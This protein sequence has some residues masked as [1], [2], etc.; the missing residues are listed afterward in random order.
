MATEMQVEIVEMTNQQNGK[1]SI[2][3]KH[4]DDFASLNWTMSAKHREANRIEWELAK[5]EA[6]GRLE[7]A[8]S[9]DNN[10]HVAL[11]SQTRSATR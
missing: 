2:P 5:K 3:S 6:R 4:A 11:I 1:E 7:G 9:E 8:D 10:E